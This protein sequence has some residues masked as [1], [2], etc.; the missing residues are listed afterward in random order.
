MENA[1]VLQ[2]HPVS[3]ETVQYSVL[4]TCIWHSL[5]DTLYV[6]ILPYILV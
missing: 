3:Q 2:L 1:Y 4:Q 5:V 6:A